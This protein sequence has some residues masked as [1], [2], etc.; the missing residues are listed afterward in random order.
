VGVTLPIRD[1]AK[2]LLFPALRSGASGI[3]PSQPSPIKGEGYADGD[4]A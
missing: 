1:N 2:A 3:T 4:A